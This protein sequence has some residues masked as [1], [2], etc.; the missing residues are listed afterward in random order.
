MSEIQ[1]ECTRCKKR[2]KLSNLYFCKECNGILDVKYDYNKIKKKSI[3]EIFLNVGFGIWRYRHLLPIKNTS[4]MISLYEGGT[5]L[6]K[7]TNI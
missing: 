7:S 3:S 6:S 2:F 1:L 4:C 5:P